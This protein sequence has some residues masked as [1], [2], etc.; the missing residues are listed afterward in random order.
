MNR[1]T[2][3]LELGLHLRREARYVV[4]DVVL[5]GLELL[6]HRV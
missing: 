5:D 4:I 3:C 1:A 6:H 2:R